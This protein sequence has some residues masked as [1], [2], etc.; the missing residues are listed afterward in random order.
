MK[1]VRSLFL[2]AAA[3]TPL[4]AQVENSH[5]IGTIGAQ[6]TIVAPQDPNLPQYR[7]QAG[8]NRFNGVVRVIMNRQD[9]TFVCTG[10]LLNNTGGTGILGAAHCFT[11]G[12]G[13][14]IT[15]SVTIEVRSAQTGSLLQSVTT[16]GSNISIK[17]GYT[18]AVVDQRDV[19]FIRLSS[20]LTTAGSGYDIFSG[21]GIMGQTIN[22]AGYGATGNGITG[23]NT[24]AQT[25]MRYGQ[26]R[27]DTSCLNGNTNAGNCAG[28]LAGNP[29]NNLNG[30]GGVLIGD[31][32]DPS[33]GF[34]NNTSLT[35]FRHGICETGVGG[36]PGEVNIGGGDSGSAAFLN[37]NNTILGVAS[38]G[39]RRVDVNPVP[40]FGAFGT[41]FGYACV[42][43]ITGNAV[44]NE[45]N[46]F[47]RGFLNPTVV[48][49]EPST[50]ALMA[51]GLVA[52]GVIARRRRSA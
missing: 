19:A 25:W 40:P 35:C 21:G 26:N 43:A 46:T 41:A 3:A 5:P 48:I 16:A 36:V 23:A 11:N 49:P 1:A 17:A 31:F 45:N 34:N 47:V 33:G 29:S 12:V 52:L 44:C 2:V 32:D 18:G 15:N 4:A 51:T 10:S 22:L 39:S 37:S 24:G 20:A 9:G 42:A 14:N 38:F 13:Q 50:Y 6:P 7:V 27:F 8:D 30:F 28:V